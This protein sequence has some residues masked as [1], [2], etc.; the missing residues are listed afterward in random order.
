MKVFEIKC[1]CNLKQDVKFEDSFDCISKFINFS[2]CQNKAYEELHKSKDFNRYC[3]GGFMPIEN[4][5]IYKKGNTYT[6]TLRTIDE[7]FAR[8]LVGLLMFNSNNEY[9]SITQIQRT[10]LRL[11]FINELYS[12]TPVIVSLKKEE[13]QKFQEYWSLTRSGDIVELQNQLQTNLLRKYKSFFGEELTP[14]Q[15]FIQ[16]L[17]IKNQKPQSIYF[18]TTKDE[19]EKR[20]R[21][22]GNKFKI[23]INE[24]EVSQKLGC[25]ALG[26]GLGEKNSYGAGFCI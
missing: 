18:T 10:E 14:S 24:D 1:G 12:A 15:S 2:I 20:I 25:I 16:L 7:K 9:I 23:I 4:D 6:F 26:T 5:R 8:D 21:L 19:K 11:G 17:E 3:F 22:F 13:G